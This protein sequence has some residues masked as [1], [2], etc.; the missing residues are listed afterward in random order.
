M[1]ESYLSQIFSEFSADIKF[2]ALKGFLQ[3]IEYNE[4]KNKANVITLRE[5]FDRYSSKFNDM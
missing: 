2:N 1:W 3:A 5:I 4:D